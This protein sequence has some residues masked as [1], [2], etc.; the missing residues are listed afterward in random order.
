MY[1][2]APTWSFPHHTTTFQIVKE[3][4]LLVR[5]CSANGKCDI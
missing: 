4:F 2:L 3:Q 1:E 5:R